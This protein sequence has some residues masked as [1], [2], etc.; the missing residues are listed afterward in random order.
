MGEG[1]G[2]RLVDIVVVGGDGIGESE[3]WAAPERGLVGGLCEDLL[4]RGRQKKS[5]TMT[6][7]L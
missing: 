3:G 4:F 2:F 6:L 5:F 7:G 1:E